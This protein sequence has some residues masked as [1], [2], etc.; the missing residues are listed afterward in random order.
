MSRTNETLTQEYHLFSA[1]AFR[2]YIDMLTASAA[3]IAG[4]A[5][6]VWSADRF[7][8]GAAATARHLGMPLLLV[9]MIVVGF[10]TSMPE[11]VVSS[12]AALQG[13]PAIAFGNAYGSN[14]A[15]I[16]LILGITAII[17]PIALPRQ[18]L[19]REI[20]I[21]LAI[22]GVAAWQAWDGQITRLDAI[23]LIAI[24]LLLM[25]WSIRESLQTKYDSLER[26]VKHEE[27]IDP[28]IAL[29]RAL[30]SLFIGLLLLIASSRLLV[31]GAVIIAKHFGVSDLIIGL[32]IVAIGTSLPE[33]ASSISAARKNEH[34]IVL[35]NVLGSNF[36]NTLL[37]V[38]IA[39]VIHPDTVDRALLTRDIPIMALL[40]FSLLF[41]GLG[42]GKSA[43]TLNGCIILLI[44]YA[45][46]TA[47][48]LRQF[49]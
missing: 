39:A 16:A 4:L 10:G 30:F 32:T 28:P 19:Q 40:T 48:L 42:T 31:W 38:G 27:N 1:T 47:Y 21:L 26:A 23:V 6:L 43:I 5:L 35:G 36:F 44:V 34:D 18:A 8:D 17:R 9:G 41:F 7:V 22:T 37:V 13:N 12:L 49:F 20:P 15:N 29:P 11:M 2:V 33:L 45:M 14:I 46:Y 24:F 3:L 25:G